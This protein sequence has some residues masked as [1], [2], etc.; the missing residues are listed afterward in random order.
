MGCN[1]ANGRDPRATAD[2]RKGEQEQGCQYKTTEQLPVKSTQRSRNNKR[3]SVTTW[4]AL[5][6]K[7]LRALV[8]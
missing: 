6:I 2:E 8:G 5:H 4:G 3:T 7:A 1:G